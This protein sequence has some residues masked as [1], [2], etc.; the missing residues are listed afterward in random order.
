MRMSTMTKGRRVVFVA[1]LFTAMG[2]ATLASPALGIVATFIIDDLGVTR[3]QLGWVI[4]TSIVLAA[5]LSPV[6]G[7][8]VDRIGG[9]AGLLVVFGVSAVAFVVFGT[10]PAFAVLFVAAALSGFAQSGANPS[11]NKLIGEDLPAG[12]RGVTTGIK[13]SGVQAAITVA[14]IVLPTLAIEFGWRIAML[15]LAAVPAAAAIVALFVIPGSRPTPSSEQTT[16]RALPVFVWWMAVYG[17][18]LGFAGAV[19]FFI[20]LFAEESLG[21]DPRLGGLAVTVTGVVAFAGRIAWARYAERTQRYL[22]SLSVV[23]VLGAIASMVMLASTTWAALLWVGAV[24]TGLSTSSW[25]SIGMLAVINEAGSATG[26]ASGVVLLGFLAG[27]GIGPPVYGATVD[28][29]GSYTAMWL[30]SVGAAALG[31]TLVVVWRRMS[32]ALTFSGAR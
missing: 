17:F 11:T 19:T 2:S 26:R 31:F 22:P 9:K 18:I 24:L 21:L 8:V 25:N 6:T 16:R 13:Q 20:A 32:S 5:L 10:A 3:G 1:L 23:A 4:G 28:A 15:A 14:G 12:E 7:W 27:L 30:I 29:T